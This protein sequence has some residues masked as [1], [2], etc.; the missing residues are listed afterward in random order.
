M[1]TTMDPGLW[2]L[3]EGGS[4]DDEVSAILRLARGAEPPKSV[5]VVSNFGE[6][7]T[8]R[9]RR[10]EIPEVRT[11]PG[12]VSLKASGMVTQPRSPGEAEPEAGSAEGEAEFDDGTQAIESPA[13]APVPG[14]DGTGVVIGI[15]DWG[16]DF[17][18]ANLRKTDG[19]TRLQCLWDQ[20]GGQGHES[21]TP[22][23]YGRMLKREAIDAALATPDPC[24]TARYHP[25]SGDPSDSGAHGTHVADIVAGSRREP[26]SEVGLASGSDL[27]FVHLA[28][29]NVGELGNLGDSV[30]LLE[31]LDF[32]RQQAAGRPCVLHLSAGK[33]GGPHR[34]DTLLERA[35]DAMLERPGIVLVQSV[36]NYAASSM[37]THAR[38][39][40]DQ[41]HT[42]DWITP[43]ADRTPNELEIWYNGQ[44]VFDVTL[45]SPDGRQF[46][47]G[48]DNR[49]QI[50]DG[51]RVW[52]N[53]YHRKLEPNS[54]M[55]HIVVF[56][57]TA[58][59]SGRWQV[60]VH[61]RDV[62]DGRLH[63]WIERDASGRYQSRFPRAQASTRFTTNTICN[64]FRA[65]AVGAYD[66][67]QP[68]KPP[69]RFSSRGPTA[70]G[71]QKPEIAAPGYRIRAARSMPRD[72]W[73]GQS[74]LCVKSGTS[75][76]APW[77]SGTVAL[78]MSAAGRPLTIHEIRRA[79]IGSADPH[80]GPSGR[81][82]TQLGYGYL[83]VTAAVAAAKRIGGTAPATRDVVTPVTPAAPK[84]FL[85]DLE[86]LEYAER[87]EDLDDDETLEDNEDNLDVEDQEGAGDLEGVEVPEGDRMVRYLGAEDVEHESEGETTGED[88]GC[89]R[90]EDTE[91][92][93]D[94]IEDTDDIEDVEDGDDV[95]DVFEEVEAEAEPFAWEDIRDAIEASDA[96]DE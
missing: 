59:P 2:E 33:T 83:N 87:G 81:S 71:R 68:S 24:A 93:G 42:I 73:Q 9:L 17:T 89:T 44:D 39:G 88:C 95:E 45:V 61:G 58:A 82:S 31:G 30:G 60:V 32:V 19:S 38:V 1:L 57:Y 79:L 25:S 18:H 16:F 66:A 27:V 51:T 43:P 21:P 85:E 84:A 3:Y 12:V 96:T 56:L 72:G 13:L 78:M 47:L 70:D 69:T 36:G 7:V 75:M 11:A 40:P 26:G 90:R 6:V 37:H 76:A 10:G 54:G 22:F 8:V 20:R 15:C 62:V 50:R 77:V 48:L 80:A 91:D 86:D 74:K 63:A 29:P 49:M 52:G 23:N 14:V 41:Q 53:F 28:A 46:P 67:T 4:S 94:D 34:G 65:I 5:R 92:D 64:C 35:V 55:N